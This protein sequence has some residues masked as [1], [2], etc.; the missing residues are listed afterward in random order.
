[1]KMVYEI[2][3]VSVV[4]GLLLLHVGMMSAQP[5]PVEKI[6]VGKFYYS[7]VIAGKLLEI[8]CL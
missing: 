8:L 3:F 6:A 1:M 7:C 5:F 2:R 4:A